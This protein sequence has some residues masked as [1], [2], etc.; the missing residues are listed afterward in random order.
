MILMSSGLKPSLRMDSTIM[1]P[2]DGMP[3]FIRMCPSEVVNRNAPSPLVPMKYK[4]PTI[5]TGSSGSS[6]L[7]NFLASVMNIL[8]SLASCSLVGLLGSSGG[9][10][11]EPACVARLRNRTNTSDKFTMRL[12]LLTVAPIDQG[13][14]GRF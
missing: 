12:A 5:R 14:H 11:C 8:L 9:N 1:G 10:A 4:G 3:V 13:Q 7:R 6:H 2:D